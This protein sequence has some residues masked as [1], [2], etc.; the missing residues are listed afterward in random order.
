MYEKYGR[1]RAGLAATVIT[2]CSRSAIRDVGKALG[3]SLDRVDALAKHVEGYT[4]EPKLVAAV[5]RGRHRSGVRPGPAA[6]LLRERDHRLPAA[7]VAARRRHGDDA[8][9]A[10][11]TGADRKRRDGRPHRHRVGQGRPRRAGHLESRLPVPGHAHGDSQVLRPGARASRP[12][13]DAGHDP[14]GRPGRVRHDLPGRH[15]RR[16]SDREPGADVDAAAA[17]AAH[18]FT[19]W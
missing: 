15:D 7:P 4:R 11:R 18:A 19:T 12:R 3:L 6:R 14:A 9:A 17:A 1:E 2:Y 13:A 10:V 5:P 16:V 8:R